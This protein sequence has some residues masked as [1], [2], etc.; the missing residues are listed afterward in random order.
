MRARLRN[1]AMIARRYGWTRAVEILALWLARQT[2]N[3]REAYVFRLDLRAF[4]RSMAAHASSGSTRVPPR[5][6]LRSTKDCQPIRT[7]GRGASSAAA[8]GC[9]A[10]RASSRTM[11]SACPIACA[12]PSEARTR[13]RRRL[14][15]AAC[16][17]RAGGLSVRTCGARAPIA[18]RRKDAVVSFRRA[19]KSG[20]YS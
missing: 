17:S 2:L 3:Y 1:L 4:Q 8:T 11:A 20:E 7:A 9:N 5:S 6:M 15:H 13:L 16:V 12:C 14:R 10:M 18:Q 19:G